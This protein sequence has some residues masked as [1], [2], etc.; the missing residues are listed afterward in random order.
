MPIHDDKEAIGLLEPLMV[1][2]G[3]P[4]RTTLNDMA[5]ASCL[6]NLVQRFLKS[7]KYPVNL[8]SPRKAARDRLQ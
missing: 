5:L 7:Y 8:N 2:E 3:A 6:L 1:N 4:Q